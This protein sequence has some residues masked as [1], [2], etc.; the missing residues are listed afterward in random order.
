M[1]TVF[2]YLWLYQSRSGWKD[3]TGS[4]Y[5]CFISGQDLFLIHR[6]L[7]KLSNCPLNGIFQKYHILNIY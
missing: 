4:F 2:M 1:A 7:L 5:V 3:G 6:C